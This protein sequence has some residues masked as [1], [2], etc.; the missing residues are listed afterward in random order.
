[1]SNITNLFSSEEEFEKLCNAAIDKYEDEIF[2]A[3]EFIKEEEKRIEK[4]LDEYED[5]QAEYYYFEEEDKDDLSQLD[6]IEASFEA[7][8]EI[9]EEIM[10]EL[11]DYQNALAMSEEEGWF[12]SDDDEENYDDTPLDKYN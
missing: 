8:E 12:Y 2:K 1:M 10:E 6:D 5:Q 11:S 7:Q 4:L 9:N 3:A